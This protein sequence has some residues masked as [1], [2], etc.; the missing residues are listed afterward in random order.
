MRRAT[1][2]ITDRPPRRCRLFFVLFCL[3][4]EL[5]GL[6]VLIRKCLWWWWYYHYY[7]THHQHQWNSFSALLL[8]MLLLLFLV[9]SSSYSFLVRKKFVMLER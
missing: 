2:D 6:L 3:L 9:F 7:T 4:D 1:K 5:V 8:L